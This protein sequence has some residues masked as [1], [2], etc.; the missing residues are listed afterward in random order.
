MSGL[1][2]RKDSC[3]LDFLAL[4]AVVHRLDPGVVPFRRA[5]SADIHVSGG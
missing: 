5:R 2:V 3:E 4:G 1:N